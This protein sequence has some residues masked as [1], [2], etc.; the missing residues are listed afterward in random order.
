MNVHKGIELIKRHSVQRHR[1]QEVIHRKTKVDCV[2]VR[3]HIVTRDLELS[4]QYNNYSLLYHTVVSV[5]SQY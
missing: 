3:V 1:N 4:L 2:R 5:N